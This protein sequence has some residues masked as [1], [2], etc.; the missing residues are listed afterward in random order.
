MMDIIQMNICRKQPS[1][2][3]RRGVYQVRLL[4][5]FQGKHLFF[6]LGYMDAFTGNDSN[7]YPMN[8][9]SERTY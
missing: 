5:R 2:R 3:L 1:F 7:L 6:S 4:S 8:I 9:K